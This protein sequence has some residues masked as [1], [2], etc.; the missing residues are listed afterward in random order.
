MAQG[1]FLRCLPFTL[2]EEG[3][4]VHDP[5]D[6]GGHT[7]RGVTQATYDHYRTSSGVARRSVSLISDAELQIIYKNEYWGQVGAEAL[8]AGVDL[9][10]FD[11]AVNSGPARARSAVARARAGSLSAAEVID[12]IATARLSC[13]HALATWTAFGKGWGARV[14]R[15]EA[16][17]LKMAGAPIR[18]A[19]DSAAAKHRN[20]KLVAKSG[21]VAAP[22]GAAGAHEIVGHDWR[23][24]GAI[25][26]LILGAAGVAVFNAWR[27]GQRATVL[28]SAA[29]AQTAAFAQAAAVKA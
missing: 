4:E 8:A 11:F 10:A 15:I 13:L 24:A 14:A 16:A 12:R 29:A 2:R 6:P 19:A 9:S 23:V 1:N 5:R 25:L 26:V 22:A 3:G 7:N 27:Q 21:A 28:A 20:A 18:T 17:S